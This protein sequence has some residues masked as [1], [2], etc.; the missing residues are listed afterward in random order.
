MRRP[1]G[2]ATW[3]DP[4]QPVVEYDSITCSHCQRVVFV[5]PGTASTVYVD[6]ETRTE[7]AGAFCRVCMRPVCLPCCAVGTCRPWEQRLEQAEARERLRRQVTGNY[8]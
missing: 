3:T 5:K 7:E 1:G 6:L 4:E 2:Y 8:R